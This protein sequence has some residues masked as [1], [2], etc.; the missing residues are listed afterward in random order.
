MRI[1]S[2]IMQ[3]NSLSNINTNKTL[4]DKLNTQM[5][6][7]KKINRPSDDPVVAIRALR[8][9]T[10]VS[11]VTQYYSKNAP[12]A[13]SWLKVTEDA[14]STVSDVITDMIKQCTSGA[15]EKLTSQDRVTILDA[16]KSLRDE[17]YATGN[18]DYAGRS[19]FTGYRTES[20]LKFIADEK[21]TYSITEHITTDNIDTIKHVSVGELNSI[22]DVNFK[23]TDHNGIIEQD[24]KTTDIHRIRLSYSD[25]SALSDYKMFDSDGDGTVD[26]NVPIIQYFD[27]TA[28]NG[29]GE[30]KTLAMAYQEDTDGDGNLESFNS[31]KISSI[32]ATPNPYEDIQ[33]K[34][35]AAILIKETG[36]LLLGANVY[37]ALMAQKDNVN[38]TFNESSI[39]V[40]YQKTNW[41]KDDLKPEHYFTC[42]DMSGNDPDKYVTYNAAYIKPGEEVEKQVIEYDIGMNQTIRINTTADEVFT[43]AIGRDVDDLINVMQ[44]VIDME[45]T[46]KKL[47]SMSENA[48]YTPDELKTINKQLDAANKALSS[49]MEKA[50]KMFE[51]GITKMQGHLDMANL[52]VTNCGT[53]SKK[54]ELVTTR[55]MSQK[56][57]F[58]TLESENENVDITE[59]AI[60]LSSAE[61]TYEAALM[62]TGKIMKT[63]LMDYI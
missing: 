55:L 15:N 54:L 34:P 38:T 29:E 9:R 13:D 8:L 45:N 28:N 12:D 46:V 4:Q 49:L 52:A 2:K 59:V 24:V 17:V 62:A 57:N 18:A 50:Q 36:E 48:V 58:E 20:T 47:E 27:A 19:V 7:E 22:N 56:T 39:L 31:I 61:L 33:N 42:T 1:T 35:D 10:N 41:E 16:L 53:R 43:H 32:D 25:V 40:T 51:S 5:A 44:S 26:T 11:Q 3:N 23:D 14:L 6:T 37:T 21:K 60:Q 30:Y 63:S